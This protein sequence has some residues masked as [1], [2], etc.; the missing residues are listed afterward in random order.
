MSN[1]DLSQEDLKRIENSEFY[2]QAKRVMKSHEEY[3]HVNVGEVYSIMYRD[4]KD[5]LTY[6]S[7]GKTKDKFMVVHKDDGFIFAKRIKSDGQLSRDVVCLTIRFPQPS[8]T[9]ELDS[10]QAEAIIFQK[11]E[12]YDPFK[13]GKE[14]S[15]KKNK[16]RRLNKPKI[17]QH[18]TAQE[19][20]AFTSTLKV[21]DTLYDAGT[22]FGEG[23]VT[24]TVTSIETRQVD[25]TPQKDWNGRV[26]AYGKTDIDQK[27]GRHQLDDLV[28][29]TVKVASEIPNSRRWMG[30][31]REVCFID[32][33]AGKERYRD[34]Y[35]TKPV[36]IEEV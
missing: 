13:E 4:F 24:W 11:E 18:A 32:F 26:Y 28:K 7:R 30:K 15:K 21:G 12:D 10:A 16:A 31:D 19:A 1:T 17:I 3:R 22:T 14:L 9:L 23:I 29:L 8:Y 27:H 35:L 25:K 36:T 34:W 33:M 6:I 20:L 5:E 2:F